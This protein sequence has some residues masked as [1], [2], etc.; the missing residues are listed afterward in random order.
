MAD[1]IN[2]EVLP[3]A[4]IDKISLYS[5]EQNDVVQSTKV[6]LR[7]A[8]KT[9]RD[10]ASLKFLNKDLD[11]F[12]K[13]S[14]VQVL[15]K[16]LAA[17]ISLSKE[18]VYYVVNVND[19][20]QTLPLVIL[21][22]AYNKGILSTSP[23]TE[24]SIQ[25]TN[26]LKIIFQNKN[27]VQVKE[28]YDLPVLKS[29]KK[30]ER[31]ESGEQVL[32]TFFNVDF[33]IEL[34]T[35]HL[36]YFVY[37]DYDS[38][39]M[40]EFFGTNFNSSDDI[41]VN[42]DVVISESKIVSQSYVYYL[43]DDSIWNG[44]VHYDESVK[45]WR[46][47]KLEDPEEFKYPL[48]RRMFYNNKIQ[49]F[50]IFNK[51][52]KQEFEFQKMNEDLLARLAKFYYQ[53]KK[54]DPIEFEDRLYNG[55][56]FTVNLDM[57]LKK[58]SKLYNFLSEIQLSSAYWIYE[59]ETYRKRVRV[60][61]GEIGKSDIVI[62]FKKNEQ[63]VAVV[64]ERRFLENGI[65]TIWI[66]DPEIDTISFGDYCYGTRIYFIDPLISLFETQLKQ[67][68]R[69]D[70]YGFLK[71]YYSQST[72]VP[73]K[74]SSGN[75]DP[76]LNKFTNNF[77]TT[78]D[79]NSEKQKRIN[80]ISTFIEAYNKISTAKINMN[81]DIVVRIVEQISPTTGSP[82]GILNFIKL[83]ETVVS[84]Y[85]KVVD[86]SKTS[87]MY[88]EEKIF[89]KDRHIVTAT[90]IPEPEKITSE[91]LTDEEN[92]IIKNLVQMSEKYSITVNKI[93]KKQKPA[94][95]GV[96]SVETA[97]V[98]E[99][100]INL[101]DQK[102]RQQQEIPQIVS[103]TAP[104]LVKLDNFLQYTLNIIG[105]EEYSQPR[106]SKNGKKR[107]VWKISKLLKKKRKRS[108][109]TAEIAAT[110][111]DETTTEQARQ[112]LSRRELI[113]QKIRERQER[114]PVKEEPLYKSIF[115][116]SVSKIID[117]KRNTENNK[118]E[119]KIEDIEE[120]IKQSTPFIQ[121]NPV[122]STNIAELNDRAIRLKIEKNTEKK[123]NKYI[124]KNNSKKRGKK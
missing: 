38:E 73:S 53:P 107:N 99:E 96:V 60:V 30:I 21:Q 83:Y 22:L 111:V 59:V 18:L 113:E 49:D 115:K 65:L 89:N 104:T 101:E 1:S 67:L 10:V 27:L 105:E 15:E 5:V 68:K 84:L 82:D 90:R 93:Q 43:S 16:N 121:N 102:D 85:Q 34:D 4:F 9:P 70:R 95:Q 92:T 11:D 2:T 40:I 25:M 66:E 51:I 117:E 31:L 72:I 88:I 124:A 52:K 120:G 80:T 69:M 63:E 110:T 54:A 19:I 46:T 109:A 58:H 28:L 81:S 119:I 14:V 87:P 35:D 23:T 50:R 33:R 76:L 12:L 78:Y 77:I 94:K 47:G 100:V 98:R 91:N 42:S 123:L 74:T 112:P 41:R 24:N 26:E 36:S 75:Y 6:Q 97:E 8:M 56:T 64:N 86:S 57:L 13:I 32:S 29:V 55:I 39:K 114:E 61:E 71:G 45:I 79:S 106:L 48:T 122:A 20:P 44:Y 3:T 118:K 108:K 62:D 17:F 116:R 103:V 7:I 37:S